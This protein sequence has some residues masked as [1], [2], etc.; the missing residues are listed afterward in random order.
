MIS[1]LLG[2]TVRMH[3]VW[4][5]IKFVS[6]F[7]TSCCTSSASNNMSV[8]L[9]QL[10]SIS[11][12]FFFIRSNHVWT[13]HD[14]PPSHCSPAVGAFIN[15]AC[16]FFPHLP[17][18]LGLSVQLALWQ[19]GGPLLVLYSLHFSHTATARCVPKISAARRNLS[20]VSKV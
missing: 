4:T 5:P 13:D 6:D 8:G 2:L 19:G 15:F 20:T 10:W 14:W 9:K 18:Q 7:N 11:S 12:F 17:P 16:L 1:A 3:C